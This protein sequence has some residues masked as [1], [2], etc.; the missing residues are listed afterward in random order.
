[1]MRA[2]GVTMMRSAAI[3][4]WAISGV[5]SCSMATAGTSWRSRHSAASISSVT[6]DFSANARISDSRTPGVTSDTSA[7]VDAGFF[8]RS[9]LRTR[10]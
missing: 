1:M 2:P 3:A 4:P 5:F 8:S 7:S 9:T 6:W 10:A